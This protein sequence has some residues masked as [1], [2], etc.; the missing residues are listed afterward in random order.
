MG[1]VTIPP[2]DELDPLT[3][4]ELART[5]VFP[6]PRVVFFPGAALPLHLFEPRYRRMV[7]DCVTRGPR[8]M[9]VTQLLPGY[10]PDYDGRPPIA[11][12]AGVGRIAWHEALPDGRHNIV[13]V[14]M[15]RCALDELPEEDGIPY[16]VARGRLL[17]ERGTASAEA[18][19]TLLGCATSLT[20]LVR[21]THPDFDLGLEASDPFGRTLDS[22]A[23]RL[24]A[25][26]EARQ[27]ALE[28]LD[29]AER[30][31]IV[32][33]SLTEL[34]GELAERESRGTPN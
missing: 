11:T 14:G 18:Q 33:A 15:A 29:V 13:L 22:I 31:R 17:E 4:D 8:I 24:V 1:F 32:T 28:A 5:P 16:R 25:D 23:D 6:L 12:V 34:L 21:R 10:E 9:A 27:C 2:F 19:K 20:S 26:P 7:E 30:A 3:P